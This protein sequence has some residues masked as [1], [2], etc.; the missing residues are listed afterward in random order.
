M[1]PQP[2]ALSEHRSLRAFIISVSL[3]VTLCVSGG[4]LGMALRGRSLIQQE[5]LNRARTDFRNI[6]HFRAWNASHG[7]VYVEKR[8][9]VESNPYLENPDIQAIDGRLYT[10][11]NPALMTRELSEML[12]LSEGYFFPIT[13]RNPLTP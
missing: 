5:M 7:G 9:G 6:V 2:T 1:T 8:P 10:K 12:K 3:A 13:S 4:F 11:K